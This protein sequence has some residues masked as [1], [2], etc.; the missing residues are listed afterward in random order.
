MTPL[1]D[2]NLT[3]SLIR[4]LE[5]SIAPSVLLL[6][7]VHTHQNTLMILEAHEEYLVPLKGLTA[8]AYYFPYNYQHLCTWPTF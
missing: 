7:P 5:F 3:P 4:T 6:L 8:I 1:M 2:I